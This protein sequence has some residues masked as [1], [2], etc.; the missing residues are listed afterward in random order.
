MSE[1]AYLG[2][3]DEIFWSPN[4][5]G[6]LL[7][8]NHIV[9]VLDCINVEYVYSKDWRLGCY[10]HLFNSILS[11]AT[12]VVAISNATRDSILRNYSIDPNKITVIPGPNDFRAEFS[13]KSNPCSSED[14]FAMEQPFVLLFSNLLPHKNTSTALTAFAASSASR[15]DIAIRVVGPVD[16]TA[17]AVCR[18]AGVKVEHYVGVDDVTLQTWL[19]SCF[20]MLSPSLEEGL[21]L[22]IGEATSMGVNVLCSDIPVHREFFDGQVRFFDPRDILSIVHA[23]DL[24]FD[25]SGPWVCKNSYSYRRS[26]DDVTKEY[27]SLF[28]GVARDAASC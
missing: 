13:L 12:A 3:K 22:P 7:A 2:R 27:L 18:A 17:L 5:R 14:L 11:N 25:E 28:Q 8:R 20:F 1:L 19:R 26:F 21:N 10:R 23:L 9:T 16:A 15:R 24:A 6:P 4:Q